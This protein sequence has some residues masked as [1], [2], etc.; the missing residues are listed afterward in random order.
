MKKMLLLLSFL[1]ISLLAVENNSIKSEL[2]LKNSGKN[3][4]K[5][6]A[7]CHGMNGERKALGKSKIIK[8][9]TEKEFITAL[10]GY[11]DGSYG[12]V[13]KGL[14]KGQIDKYSE[15]DFISIAKFLELSTEEV[16]STN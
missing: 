6:C 3:L 9:F 13:M 10:N 14:M 1:S 4:F 15:E 16:N 7:A 5:K 11:K 8:N 12:G 2:E